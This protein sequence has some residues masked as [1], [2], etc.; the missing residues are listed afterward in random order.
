MKIKVYCEIHVEGFKALEKRRRTWICYAHISAPC[1]PK[2]GDEL[3]FLDEVYEGADPAIVT[4]S[5]T[6]RETKAGVFEPEI[7]VDW[8]IKDYI[9]E[10]ST[11]EE[12][13]TF[14]E[15]EVQP[16]LIRRAWG[17]DRPR[18]HLAR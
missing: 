12:A 4:H 14:F 17:F 13:S 1:L 11:L 7:S 10:N 15:K 8:H 18:D 9:P 6:F 16:S 2:E 3:W 5:S